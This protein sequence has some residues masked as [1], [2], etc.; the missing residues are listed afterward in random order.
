MISADGRRLVATRGLRGCADGLIAASLAG[1]L[2]DELGYSGTRIGVIVTGMLL[3]SA[4]LTMFTGAWGWRL[5]RR[6]LLRAGALLMVVTGIVFSTS[7]TFVVLL[8]LG[9][10]GTMN[11]SGSDVNV[12]QPIEQ[13]L[14]PMTSTDEQRS[15][16]FATYT[17]VGGSL[18][19]LGALSAGLPAR[20]GW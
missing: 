13:S 2:G 11:P 15:R 8:V 18:A 9:V 17:F 12:V 4:V 16:T 19:A 1:Y 6:S 14:L 5:S 10:I 20:A 7:T 3:G